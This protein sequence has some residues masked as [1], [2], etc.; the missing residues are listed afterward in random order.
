MIK[1]MRLSNNFCLI[2]KKGK[3]KP[4][5]VGKD[6]VQVI[7]PAPVGEKD[8]VRFIE[9]LSEHISDFRFKNALFHC[10]G[11]SDY[12]ELVEILERYRKL[13]RS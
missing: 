12:S 11:N 5:R 3:R 10:M 13:N 6:I 8:F 1:K 9:L 4:S 2:K 7:F